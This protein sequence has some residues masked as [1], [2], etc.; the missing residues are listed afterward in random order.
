MSYLNDPREMAIRPESGVTLEE[1]N[2]YEEMWHW[3]AAVLDLCNLPVEEYMKPMTVI[4]VGG[5]GEGGG[6]GEG[7][8]TTVTYTLKFM[9]DGRQQGST[10]KL[11]EGAPIPEVTVNKEGYDFSGWADA[12]GNTPTTMPASNLTLYGTTTIKKFTVK[13]VVDGNEL[14]EYEQ[15]V[16]WNT[17][18]TNIPSSAKTG[19]VFSGWEPAIPSTI[20]ND[21]TFTGSFTKKSYTV[22]FNV[23]GQLQTAEFEYGDAIEYP[24]PDS[25]EGYTICGWTPYYETMPDVN[26]VVFKAVLSAN[27]YNI[28]FLLVRR[29]KT[30]H[31]QFS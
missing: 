27:S 20:K 21:Y 30:Q 17:K 19:Y 16:N 10:Y 14:S 1:D 13:F 28:L 25:K 8:S 4:G 3:G 7:S 2:R 15:T 18:V 22:T 29:Y 23:S 6:S 12:S 9:L 11:E 26:N 5:G 24:A 31:F